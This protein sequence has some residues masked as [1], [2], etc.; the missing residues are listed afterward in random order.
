MC[1]V[2]LHMPFHYKHFTRN[3]N[4][5]SPM[6][7][8]N[9]KVRMISIIVAQNEEVIHSANVE[10]NWTFLDLRNDM[11]STCIITNCKFCIG[12][13]IVRPRA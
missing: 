2:E 11:L 4:S 1:N 10:Q 6:D 13:K 3:K 12:D 8:L 7:S 9:E 5:W